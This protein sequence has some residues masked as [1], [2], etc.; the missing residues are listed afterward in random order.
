MLSARSAI[1]AALAAS[2]L[3][4]CSMVGPDFQSPPAQLNPSWLNSGESRVAEDPGNNG[5]WWR[6]FNDP[7]L[8]RLI[9]IGYAQNLPLQVAG[10]T[11]AAVAGA[12]GR[13]D[14]RGVPADTAGCGL[15]RADA[16]ERARAVRPARATPPSSSTPG[17]RVGVQ[18]SWELDLWGKFRRSVE[19]ADAQL[20]AS[21]ANYDD[22]LVSL[23]ADL[24][25]AYIQLRTLQEQLRV[26]H[27][28]VKVQEEGLADRDRRAFAAASPTSA[29]SSR[30]RP[31]WPR[32]RPRSR[33]S[34]SRS[35][36]PATRSRR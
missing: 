14:R 20:A 22:V 1:L 17:Q 11:G 15:A 12:A 6:T 24:A 7:A 16:G 29:T 34:S 13:D 27:A 19:F 3:S 10:A 5:E 30:R 33:S 8:N 35:S 28:N 18:A 9:E 31:S 2:L 21:V 23:T 26:A 36:R 25:T 32:P 4:G